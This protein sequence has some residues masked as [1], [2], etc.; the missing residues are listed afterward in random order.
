MIT[1]ITNET[2]AIPNAFP[3]PTSKI[4]LKSQTMESSPSKRAR[5]WLT[6]ETRAS[7][8]M[9]RITDNSVATVAL[10]NVEEAENSLDD[11]QTGTNAMIQERRIENNRIKSATKG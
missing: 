10:P 3:H 6:L 5:G 4:T 8:R 9:N 2:T 11:S 1:V 7:I